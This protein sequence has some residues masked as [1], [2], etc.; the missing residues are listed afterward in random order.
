MIAGWT[1]EG[2]R[3]ERV[4]DSPSCPLNLHQSL[5]ATAL[6]LRLTMNQ[7]QSFS[8]IPI[9]NLSIRWL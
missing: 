3:K 2:C 9:P 5:L 8:I 7:S 1:P 4:S 6:R